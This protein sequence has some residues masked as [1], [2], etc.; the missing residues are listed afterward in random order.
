MGK[1]K[2]ISRDCQQMWVALFRSGFTVAEIAKEFGLSRQS[3][4]NSINRLLIDKIL[5]EHKIALAHRQHGPD[6]PDPEEEN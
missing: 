5:L 6:G 3:I 1:P 2:K 4:Y